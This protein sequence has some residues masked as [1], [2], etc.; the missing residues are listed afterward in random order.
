MIGKGPI[1]IEEGVCNC[2]KAPSRTIKYGG[3]PNLWILCLFGSCG[4]SGA[5]VGG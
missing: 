4:S 1:S 2:C 5:E 3:R